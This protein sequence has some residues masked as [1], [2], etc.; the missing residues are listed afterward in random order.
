M[1]RIS[2]L[3]D[4]YTTGALSAF[5][6]SPRTSTKDV[7]IVDSKD[8]LYKV[9]NKLARIAKISNS[10]KLFVKNFILNKT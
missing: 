7:A 2:S 10:V 3:D 4:T 1:A 6:S 9:S 5:S 8:T